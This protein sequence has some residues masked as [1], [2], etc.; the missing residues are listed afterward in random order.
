MTES[1]DAYATSKYPG[2]SLPTPNHIRLVSLLPGST[3]T[4]T[5]PEYEALSYTW[6]NASD[7]QAINIQSTSLQQSSELLATSN[8]ASAL[9]RL[10]YKDRPRMLWV[11][12]LA[13]NQSD[14]SEK[15]H[16]L[17]L[18]SKIYSQATKVIIYLG[19]SADNSDLATEF[20]TECDYPSSDTTSLSYPKSELLTDALYS[21]FRRPWFT[22]VWV[23]QEAFLS[24]AALAYCG[25]KTIPW[26]A[27]ENFNSW[28][29]AS[30]WL[31]QLPFVIYASEKLLIRVNIESSMFTA[32]SRTRHCS[33][34]NQCDKVYALLPLFQSFI[35]Q[36]NITPNY[37]DTVAKVYTDCAIALLPECGFKLLSA[38]QGR[39]NIDDL[40][41]WVP[42]WSMAR[43]RSHV[44]A[45]DLFYFGWKVSGEQQPQLTAH[46]SMDNSITTVSLRSTGHLC[47]RISGIGS[48][49]VVGRNPLPLLEWQRL[50]FANN[51]EHVV[52]HVY[53][54]FT[55]YRHDW[56][57]QDY[58]T[59]LANEVR[60]MASL[61]RDK[62]AFEEDT[63]PF[64][65]IPFHLAASALGHSMQ[66]CVQA[67]LRA[68]H[69]RRF[70]ITDTGYMGIAPDNAQ[71]MDHI[72]ICPGSDV[73]FVFREIDGKPHGH[74]MKQFRLIGQ[75]HIEQEAWDDIGALPN[76]LG[77]LKII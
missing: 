43:K 10:R 50:A 69:S 19:E 18:M 55:Y 70:F 7:R 73:P 40:P 37:G 31:R 28:N 48:A 30:K 25:E 58:E 15:N 4:I 62:K 23:I 41:S 45:Y 9:H 67:V 65:D 56:W 71:I 63:L 32:L 42:D 44:G 33:A 68:C 61:R 49:Y 13:I 34:T 3:N 16:Q 11:D 22:R 51:E 39:S 74:G 60:R 24:N 47:G 59:S 35:E 14:I 53:N 26:S 17:T 5:S 76:A 77:D 72:Y 36:L 64:E 46:V 52:D 66:V 2:P 1:H 38:V 12:S 57:Y 54:F 21:F 75:S 6:G 8:C 29:I 20:I 27:I